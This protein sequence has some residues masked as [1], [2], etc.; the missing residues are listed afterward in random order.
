MSEA[1][2]SDEPRRFTAFDRLCYWIGYAISRAVLS[3][4]YRTAYRGRNNLPRDGGVLLVSNHQSHLDPPIVG[5][6]VSGRIVHFIARVGLYNNALFGWMITRFH[7][8]PIREDTGDMAAIKEALKRLEAGHVVCIFAEGTRSP[9]GTL[10]PFKRGVALLLKRSRCP[11]IP[12][13]IEGAYDVMPRGRSLPKLGGR[14]AV[15]IGEPI[16]HDELLAGGADGALDALSRTVEAMR[17]EL[18]EALR[19][20]TKGKFPPEGP[21]DQV[22][23]WLATDNR[24]RE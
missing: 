6:A 13:A 15:K 1:P 10:Q 17:L 8:I 12:V 20:K 22:A 18:R 7:T 21:A 14:L 19:A 3:A 16:P 5:T 4:L 24:D 2:A 9:D 11:V 23:S